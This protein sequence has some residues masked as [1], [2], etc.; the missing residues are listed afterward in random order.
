MAE[1]TAIGWTDSTFNPWIGCTKISP[2][3]DGCYAESGNQ[4]FHQGRNWG[5][6]APRHRTRPDNWRL[7]VK[8]NRRAKIEQDAGISKRWLVFCA[9]Q[10]DIF[11]NEVPQ[12]WRDDLWE[13]IRATPYLTWQLV[14]KRIGNALT[15]LPEDWGNGY[16][17]VWL[18]STIVNQEEADRD[19]TKL[20]RVPA[21]I[22]G[23]SYE[24]ALGEVDWSRY[25]VP[26]N[27]SENR[28]GVRLDWIIV[29][30]ESSQ[31]NHPARPFVLGW[32]K[33]T[34]AQCREAGVACFVKQLGS[35]PTNREGERHAGISGK[36]DQPHE[37]PEALRVQELPDTSYAMGLST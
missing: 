30:G 17:N 12:E 34:I 37:W 21:I 14:T 1:T 13:L 33:R 27:H 18:I 6:G 16:P 20:L 28:Y 26:W 32:A 11:D 2:G 19:I 9:S 4:R 23:V 7:P 5:S 25:L 8:W 31:P 24:P 3:C 35:R 15:M 29:G 36:G 10:A 22:H